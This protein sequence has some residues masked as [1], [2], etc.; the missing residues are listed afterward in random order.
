[1]HRS[2]IIA[3][4][5]PLSYSRDFLPV[6][7]YIQVS[8][9]RDIFQGTYL[10]LFDLLGQLLSQLFI[11]LYLFSER[12]LDAAL[13]LLQL[14][15]LGEGGLKRDAAL[16]LERRRSGLHRAIMRDKSKV[17]LGQIRAKRSL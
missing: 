17:K 12:D 11:F 3:L 10:A 4:G 14:F 2:R 9:R 15:D 1:M 7:I 13:T 6:P 16:L 8:I 5:F